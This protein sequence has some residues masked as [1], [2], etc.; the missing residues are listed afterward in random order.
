MKYE[1]ICNDYLRVL[2]VKDTYYYIKMFQIRNYFIGTTLW[3]N[4]GQALENFVHKYFKNQDCLR[5]SAAWYQ[6]LSF[7]GTDQSNQ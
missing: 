3:N 1:L 7:I 5:L 6:V 2:I 4:D